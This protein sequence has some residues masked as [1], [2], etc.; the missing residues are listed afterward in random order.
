MVPSICIHPYAIQEG[1]LSYN[2]RVTMADQP[3][4]LS[5]QWITLGM[6]LE[7]MEEAQEED[8]PSRGCRHQQR[9]SPPRDL[10]NLLSE[11]PPPNPYI[12]GSR[13]GWEAEAA[14]S[15]GCGRRSKGREASGLRIGVL[16][17]SAAAAA[18][19]APEAPATTTASQLG[20]VIYTRMLLLRL[21]EVNL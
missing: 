19:H 18:A 15:W 16:V 1:A 21:T 9:L 11:P 2:H 4:I 12:I 8:D 13:L 10:P 20:T 3:A 17:V 7:G 5:N 6:D 14:R